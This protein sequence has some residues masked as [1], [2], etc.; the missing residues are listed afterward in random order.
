L[1][2]TTNHKA[3]RLVCEKGK[4]NT[5]SLT[6]KQRLDEDYA[7]SQRFAMN[8]GNE[9]FFLF[10]DQLGSTNGVMNARW[11]QVSVAQR[12]GFDP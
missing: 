4:K 10:G 3:G 6:Q 1:F 8:I 7:D 2:N 5:F 12:R 9:T 11:P